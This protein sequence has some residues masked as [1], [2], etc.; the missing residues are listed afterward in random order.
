MNTK[1]RYFSL[2]CSVFV[3]LVFIFSS[4]SCKN[5]QTEAGFF[6]KNNDWIYFINPVDHYFLYKMKEDLTQ[7]QRVSKSKI[8]SNFVIQEDW[9]YFADGNNLL[10]I[11]TNGKEKK[12]LFHFPMSLFPFE[13]TYTT[14]N[15]IKDEYLYFSFGSYRYRNIY[16]IKINGTGVQKITD[17]NS[18]EN[19]ILE[20]E[21]IYFINISDEEKIYPAFP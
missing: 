8:R 12:K 13:K 5:Y 14:F 10:R 21:W 4:L 6:T 16:R 7:K 15:S 9:I 20:K 19:F 1:K 18:S 11:S 3:L 2:I 17:F